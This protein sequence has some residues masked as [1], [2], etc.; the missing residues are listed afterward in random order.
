MTEGKPG[1]MRNKVSWKSVLAKRKGERVQCKDKREK[2]SEITSRRS[3]PILGLSVHTS[4]A[5]LKRA[6][7][8][9]F[10]MYVHVWAQRVAGRYVYVCGNVCVFVR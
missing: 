5:C 10:R 7:Y 1:A 3:L 6:F 9:A 4:G 2:H 8:K